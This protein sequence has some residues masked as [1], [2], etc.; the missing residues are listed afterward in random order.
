MEP[1][2][3]LVVDDDLS[4]CEAT[5]EGLREHGYR[6]ETV[7]TGSEA[8]EYLQHHLPDALVLDI[9]LP[10]ISGLDVLDQLRIRGVRV[11]TVV[12]S[13]QDTAFIIDRAMQLGARAILRKPT[14]LDYVLEALTRIIGRRPGCTNCS[15][16]P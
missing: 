6:V 3:V 12:V 14:A 15:P 5:A 13:A 1:L 8:I 7:H 10:D 9:Q 2:L 11:P 16:A 4:W